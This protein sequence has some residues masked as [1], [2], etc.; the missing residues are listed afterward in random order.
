[1]GR[2]SCFIVSQRRSSL[3]F[4]LLSLTVC[5]YF[6]RILEFIY[7]QFDLFDIISSHDPFCNMLASMF[8]RNLIV[9]L[10]YDSERVAI[11]NF[12]HLGEFAQMLNFCEAEGGDC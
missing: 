10:F 8:C 3:L 4:Q 5:T 1:M 6:K 9:H 2:V 11:L 7:L 12:R